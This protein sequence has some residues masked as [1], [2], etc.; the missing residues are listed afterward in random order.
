MSNKPIT[1]DMR[2]GLGNQMMALVSARHFL[3]PNTD[4][5]ITITGANSSRL[6][7]IA[8]FGF[9]V[10][11]TP[12]KDRRGAGKL[13]HDS[14]RRLRRGGTLT[15][16]LLASS[17]V[18]W[19]LG[20]FHLT[21]RS[22]SVMCQQNEP[23][24]KIPK[25][26]R[27]VSGFFTDCGYLDTLRPNFRENFLLNSRTRSAWF[28]HQY[29]SI[30]TADSVG[31]HVRRGDFAKIQDGILGMSYYTAALHHLSSRG[32]NLKKMTVWLFSDDPVGAQADFKSTLPHLDFQVVDAP[33]ETPAAEVLILLAS[34]DTIIAANSTFSWCAVHMS[35]DE[36]TALSPVS[37]ARDNPF[38]DC[39]HTVPVEYR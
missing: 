29:E 13:F 1:L 31:I 22:G 14:L 27:R 24:N 15:A 30:T 7:S 6:D 35:S 39:S 9:E 19:L 38:A 21:G 36:T 28:V 4:Y 37:P 2:G 34:C 18:K 10:S 16:W 3:G 25:R 5:R 8:G 12:S 23:P 26:I 17:P 32:K 11:G 33:T 20:Q